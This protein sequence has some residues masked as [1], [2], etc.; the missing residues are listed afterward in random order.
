MR[1]GAI[2]AS[3]TVIPKSSLYFFNFALVVP[4]ALRAK[5]KAKRDEE[6]AAEKAQ[7]QKDKS[8]YELLR[9]ADKQ[10]R[11]D[12]READKAEKEIKAQRLKA[13][14]QARR[15]KQP[16][17]GFSFLD[18]IVPVIPESIPVCRNLAT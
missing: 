6:R 4:N 15:D 2:N 3:P 1:V 17:S 9:E 16:T 11:A 12:A 7:A 13:K 18:A 8:E 5:E 14:I 10:A